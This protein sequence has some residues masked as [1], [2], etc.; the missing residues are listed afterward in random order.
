MPT[1]T[2]VSIKL[3]ELDLDSHEGKDYVKERTELSEKMS[4]DGGKLERWANRVQAQ[5]ASAG[6]QMARERRMEIMARFESLGY[7]QQ[8]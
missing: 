2:K 8:E 6:Y 4:T 3:K 7:S 5:K 1:A